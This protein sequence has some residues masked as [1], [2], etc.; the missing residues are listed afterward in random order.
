LNEI[1]Q[2]N[3]IANYAGHGGIQTWAS[4]GL[5]TNS[6]LASLTNA[7]R[8]PFVIH[9]TC[10]VGYFHYPDY[11]DTDT[12]SLAE[13]LVRMPEGGAIAS[14]ASSGLGLASG[15]DFLDRGILQAIFRDNQIHIGAAAAQ[16]KLYL[17]SNTGGYRDLIDLYTLFGDPATQ[18]NV[19]LADVEIGLEANPEAVV[20]SGE[21]ITYTLRYLNAGDALASGVVI[22]SALPETI[23]N[24]VI[25]STGAEITQNLDSRFT[26]EVANLAPGQ[27]GAITITGSVDSDFIGTISDQADITTPAMERR[28][29]NN[30]A[31]PIETRVVSPNVVPISDLDASSVNSGIL[32][33]WRTE[34]ELNLL[35]FNLYRSVCPQGEKYLLNEGLI[36]SKTPGSLIG[37]DYTYLDTTAQPGSEYCDWLEVVNLLNGS[38]YYAFPP[39]TAF[40]Y[41]HIPI[42]IK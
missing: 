15:Q 29:D 20:L 1:N 19:P 40:F 32:L 10:L 13:A 17:Y 27:G 22:K 5:L 12:S 26:W 38:S 4:E 34:Q 21:P 35:G 9:M 8:L 41:I 33:H 16:A 6:S 23:H 30:Y 37:N 7:G 18:L 14:W 24:P 31:G 3:L 28:T 2:G 36:P 25:T 42:V 39:V 11:P